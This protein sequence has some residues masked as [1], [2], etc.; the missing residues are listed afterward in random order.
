M[1]SLECHYAEPGLHHKYDK[2]NKA[3]VIQTQITCILRQNKDQYT[4]V[5]KAD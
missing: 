5:V 3:I 2:C 1:A 4:F